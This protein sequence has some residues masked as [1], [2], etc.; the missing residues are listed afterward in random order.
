[1]LFNLKHILLIL[2]LTFSIKGKSQYAITGISGEYYVDIVPDTIIGNV[3]IYPAYCQEYDTIDFNSDGIKDVLFYSGNVQ[4]SA[5]FFAR[6]EVKSLDSNIKFGFGST[7]STW[8]NSGY[9]LV[10]DILKKWNYLDTINQNNFTP[11]SFGHLGYYSSSQGTTAASNQWYNANDKYIGVS[12]FDTPTQNIYFGWIRVTIGGYSLC[13]IKDYG[14]FVPSET[15]INKTESKFINSIFFP[16][17]SNEG[18]T[19]VLNRE[20]KK[21]VFKL[22]DLNSKTIEIESIKQK[23]SNYFI[24][25]SYVLNGIYFL[26]IETDEGTIRKKIVIQH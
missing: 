21:A 6:A 26:I 5:G 1:M 22:Y 11:V 3:L 10:R 18:F 25:T 4:S 20:V 9:W 7:D 13:T 16:N 14:L 2:I 24:N 15:S 12:F 17:P 19:F 23:E 8:H